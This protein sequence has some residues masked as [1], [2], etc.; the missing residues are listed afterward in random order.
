LKTMQFMNCLVSKG[1]VVPVHHMMKLGEGGIARFI[2]N[3][4][5]G[6]GERSAVHLV[7]F[8]SGERASGTYHMRSRVG[9][10]SLD[11]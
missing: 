7:C 5:L 4:A 11:P 10:A 6:E 3:S 2:C 9:R 1:K 8:S